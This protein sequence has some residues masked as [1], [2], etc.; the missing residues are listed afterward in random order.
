VTFTKSRKWS[1]TVAFG[2]D[3]GHRLTARELGIDLPKQKVGAALARPK[4][5]PASKAIVLVAGEGPPGVAVGKSTRTDVDRALGAPLEDVPTGPT[6]RNCSYRG[7]PHVQL[8]RGGRA[9]D[10]GHARLVRRQDEGRCR[11][12]HAARR[13]PAEARRGREIA[14]RGRRP[15]G[16]PGLAVLFD[17]AGA[18]RRLVVTRR[19]S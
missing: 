5:E 18:V 10:G 15:V 1:L 13:R 7:E 3:G 8:R 12:R 16:R 11:A 9:A 6:N 19:G 14:R 4:P 17:S 2:A